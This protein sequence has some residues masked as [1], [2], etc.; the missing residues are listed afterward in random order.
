MTFV[1]LLSSAALVAQTESDSTSRID[2]L[3]AHMNLTDGQVTCLQ[4]NRAAFRD[5][6]SPIAEDLRTA[7]RSL[8]QA[9]RN[10][11]DTSAFQAEVDALFA[12]QE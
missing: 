6:A 4:D 5:A 2:D 9:T 3:V 10:G 1:L 7:Q 12:Q 8:R 11:E